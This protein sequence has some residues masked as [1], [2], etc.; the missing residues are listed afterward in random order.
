LIRYAARIPDGE[1]I[2]SLDA[3]TWDDQTL[4]EVEDKINLNEPTKFSSK[5]EH[6]S[7]R[8]DVAD[9]Y[10]KDNLYLREIIQYPEKWLPY[11]ARLQNGKRIQAILTQVESLYPSMLSEKYGITI[12]AEDIDGATFDHIKLQLS[13]IPPYVGLSEETIDEWKEQNKTT[14]GVPV[15]VTE[16]WE[17]LYEAAKGN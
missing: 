15:E 7:E 9:R 3:S 11:I 10:I 13:A 14:N 17:K 2:P 4:Q 5:Q 1:S 6:E 12:P 16:R 8:R